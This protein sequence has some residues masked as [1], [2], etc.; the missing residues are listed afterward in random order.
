MIDI[1]TMLKTA[2][3]CGM[4]FAPAQFTGVLEAEISEFELDAYT[5]AVT[6]MAVHAEREACARI[7]ADKADRLAQE[8]EQADR[9]GDRDTCTS[10]RAAAHLL[11]VCAARIRARSTGGEG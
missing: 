8:A 5:R 2:K 11:L 10:N 7:N 3:D 1:N 4:K 9:E 6:Q